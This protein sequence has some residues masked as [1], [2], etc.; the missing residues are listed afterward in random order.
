VISR[1]NIFNHSKLYERRVS[2]IC[3]KVD[4]IIG[5]HLG[6]RGRTFRLDLNVNKIREP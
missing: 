5:G 3:S 1:K 2:A 6:N 4:G